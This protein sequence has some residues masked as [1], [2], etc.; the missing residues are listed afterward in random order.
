MKY[1]VFL[2]YAREDLA[3]VKNLVSAIEAEGLTVFWDRHI[4]L[5]QQWSDVLERALR[6]SKVIVVAWS[7]TSVKS[8]W[9]KAEAT[10]AMARGRLVPIR[11]D[12]ATIPMPFGQVQTADV[13]LDR[14]LHEQGVSIAAAIAAL[15][16][17]P[18]SSPSV[19]SKQKTVDSFSPTATRTI[20]WRHAFLSMVAVSFGC[21][22]WHYFPRRRL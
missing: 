12:A 11:I 9:V 21:A 17:N 1:D 3:A 15:D 8:A 22:T 10:E 2:S 7:V 14:P 20:N 4:Q 13:S 5:G 18:N 16:D 19:A 6:E